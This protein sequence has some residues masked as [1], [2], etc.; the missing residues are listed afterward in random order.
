MRP[1]IPDRGHRLTFPENRFRW[2]VLIV[3]LTAALIA[4]TSCDS[5]TSQ[6]S[7]VTDH[8][9]LP[10]PNLRDC[11]D[12]MVGERSSNCVTTLRFLLNTRGADLP[13]T[14]LFLER[15]RDRV[16]QFQR[17]RELPVTGVVDDRT[18]EELYDYPPRG[19]EWDL[20]TDCVDM[21]QGAEGHCV[22]SLR[23]LLVQYGEEMSDIGQYGPETTEAVR[24]F[25]RKHNLSESGVTDSGTKEELYDQLSSVAPPDWRAEVSDCS[26]ADCGSV[27]LDQDT[28]TDIVEDFDTGAIVRE[29]IVAVVFRFA[30]AALFKATGLQVVC[31]QAGEWITDSFIEEFRSA[32]GD[33]ECVQISFQDTPEGSRPAGINQTE[34]CPT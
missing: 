8:L 7:S 30:C 12:L 17:A 22:R 1:T 13:A 2:G 25:Q 24:R 9:A 34:R 33:Q 18:K 11:P 28:V 32:Q 26:G 14:G 15:T 21:Y 3:A 10:E 23:R 16:R 6:A 20:R 27:Y 31:E 19:E 4:T 5:P 29:L